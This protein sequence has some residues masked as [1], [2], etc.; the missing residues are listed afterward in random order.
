MRYQA[1]MS[2]YRCGAWWDGIVEGLLGSALKKE[3][4][5]RSEPGSVVES[6]LLGALRVGWC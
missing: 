6:Q 1:G 3:L 5:Q 4:Y 2:A